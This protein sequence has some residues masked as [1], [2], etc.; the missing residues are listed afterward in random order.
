MYKGSWD[1]S[2]SMD[3]QDAEGAMGSDAIAEWKSKLTTCELDWQRTGRSPQESENG[4]KSPKYASGRHGNPQQKH[5][6]RHTN[7]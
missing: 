2:S 7:G 1:L 5:G 6:R 4:R 3:G